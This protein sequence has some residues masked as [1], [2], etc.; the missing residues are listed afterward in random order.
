MR[1][2]VSVIDQIASRP[3][4]ALCAR[5][6]AERGS[7]DDEIS[8]C[9]RGERCSS[10]LLRAF[11][12][13]CRL[14]KIPGAIFN[15][16]P[17][18]RSLSF[19]PRRAQSLFVLD[20]SCQRRSGSRWRLRRRGVEKQAR[21]WVALSVVLPNLQHEPLPVPATSAARQRRNRGSRLACWR[22]V[23]VSSAAVDVDCHPDSAQ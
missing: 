3:D 9:S 13:C 8:R 4:S 5:Y 6:G 2:R 11:E 21:E 23:T 7:V 18:L 15:E 19:A 12:L 1:G 20:S 10:S 22:F 14:V 16:L 17:T